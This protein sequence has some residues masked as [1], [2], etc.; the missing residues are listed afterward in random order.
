[1]ICA[2][3]NEGSLVI[4][5]AAS[6]GKRT[7]TVWRPSVRLSVPSFSNLNRARGAYST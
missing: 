1:M 2:I 7:A 5:L 3:S 6:R 4:T